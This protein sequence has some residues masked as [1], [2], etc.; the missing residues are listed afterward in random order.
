MQLHHLFSLFSMDDENTHDEIWEA[1]LFKI[2]RFHASR[3]DLESTPEFSLN[4]EDDVMS[5]K[6]SYRGYSTEKNSRAIFRYPGIMEE[7][8]EDALISL[9]HKRCYSESGSISI[10][11]SLYELRNELIAVKKTYSV[12]ELRLSLRTLFETKIYLTGN[13]R[14]QWYEDL[15][16]SAFDHLSIRDASI[17]SDPRS[18]LRFSKFTSARII[19]G[20]FS[21]NHFQRAMKMNTLSRHIYKFLLRYRTELINQKIALSAS[22]LIISSPV[23]ISERNPENTR[24]IRDALEDL[25]HH[26]VIS[27]WSFDARMSNQIDIVII[28]DDF[29]DKNQDQDNSP[30]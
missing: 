18:S 29:L 15:S 25:Y 10:D 17:D 1:C 2:P 13:F 26:K 9:A 7:N 24:R 22:S 4:Y 5:A 16:Y 20:E 19:S 6:L 23:I 11:F 30:E 27:E 14:G 21:R 8:V 28:N 3:E 12:R